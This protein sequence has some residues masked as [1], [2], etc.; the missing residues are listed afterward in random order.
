MRLS[1]SAT[2]LALFLCSGG[3]CHAQSPVAAPGSSASTEKFFSVPPKDA[4]ELAPLGEYAVGVRT[5][6]LKNPGQ[7]DIL[8]FDKASGKAPLYDRP[9][10][11]EIWYPATLTS[12][13]EERTAYEMILPGPPPP[14]PV[15]KF[16]VPGKALRDAVPV[17]G[18]KFP[19]VIV[20]H[21]Y[22]GSRFFLSYLTE[23]LASK[24]YVVAAIDHTDSVLG[25]V[26]P[27]PSTLLNRSADQ[28]FTVGSA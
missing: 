22:P 24:G 18:K 21:G 11:V 6:E 1:W 15:K 19:L 5:V 23:N 28:L 10:T 2:A 3:L 17:G 20:S 14:Q 12:G 4:P 26:K 13:Q 25:A 8:N 7:I 27:F 9:L 16:L